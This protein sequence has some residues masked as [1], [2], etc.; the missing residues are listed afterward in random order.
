MDKGNSPQSIYPPYAYKYVYRRSPDSMVTLNQ[1]ANVI[2]V[3][4]TFL[5]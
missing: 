5:T 3:H 1:G 2:Q 4:K